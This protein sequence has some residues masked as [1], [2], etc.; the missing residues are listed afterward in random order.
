[1]QKT[2]LFHL[3]IF[4]THL[5][6]ISILEFRDQKDDTHFWLCLPKK[7]F[8]QLLNFVNL[9][10]HAKNQFI[11][12]VHSSDTVNFRVPWPDWPRPFLTM[13]TQKYHFLLYVGFFQ[14]AKNQPIPYVHSWDAVN[15]TVPKPDL[16]HQ[17]FWL[18]FVL[19][20]WLIWKSYNPIGWEH[21]GLDFSKKIFP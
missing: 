19:T 10:Q 8:D 18:K 2:S 17:F 7:F 4:E 11:S 12:S 15:F 13:P 3:L 20:K 6:Y 1:M 9:Y 5:F 21:F 16:P 14:P